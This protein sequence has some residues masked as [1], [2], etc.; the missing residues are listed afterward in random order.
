MGTT[1]SGACMPS[2]WAA[3]HQANAQ[4]ACATILPLIEQVYRRTH[5][6]MDELIL[7]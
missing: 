5:L 3:S 4:G 6:R 7:P 1:S 2:L